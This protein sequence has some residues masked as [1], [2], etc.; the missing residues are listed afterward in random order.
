MPSTQWTSNVR[1]VVTPE[2]VSCH[3]FGLA[4][5]SGSPENLIIA[6][7]VIVFGFANVWVRKSGFIFYLCGNLICQTRNMNIYNLSFISD[8]DIYNHVKTTVLQYRRNIDLKE[9]N[10][11]IIDPIKLTFDAKIYGEMD[12]DYIGY[13]HQ[14]LFKYVNE[15][16]MTSYNGFDV[17]NEK[18]HIYSFFTDASKMKRKHKCSIMIKMFDKVLKDDKAHC[19]VVDIS[20][21]SQKDAH[22]T[23]DVDKQTLQDERIHHVSV[24]TF[25]DLAFEEKDSYLKVA[26]IL[27]NVLGDVLKYGKVE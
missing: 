9:F 27:S 19:Y 1:L 16:W 23:Y 8:E 17:V 24:S 2:N 3:A 12:E 4:S 15:D 13:F 5:V 25:Y 26:K 14:S 18:R 20:D 11:N 6:N 7:V 21:C 10:K 22:F